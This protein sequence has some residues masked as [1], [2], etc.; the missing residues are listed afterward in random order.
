MQQTDNGLVNDE[1]GE[2]ADHKCR[3]CAS[4][5]V[6][7]NDRT[8]WP[9]STAIAGSAAAPRIAASQSRIT[10]RLMQGP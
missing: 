3:G 8:R 4:K 1:N 5:R 7:P 2:T 9:S 10:H 6:C